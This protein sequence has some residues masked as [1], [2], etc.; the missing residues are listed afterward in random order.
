M[1][2][3]VRWVLA[4][5]L[6]VITVA[7]L[8]T[9]VLAMQA[10]DLKV[11]VD[12]NRALP[13]GHPYVATTRRIEAVFGKSNDVVVG[14]TAKNGDAFSPQVLSTVQRITTSLQSLPTVTSVLSLSAAR[15][16]GIAAHGD[17]VAV[18]P[19][20]PTVPM[21]P[22]EIDALRRAL[23]ANPVYR[24]AIISDD[25][26]TA[27]ILAEFKESAAGF[28]HMI[29]S[30][31]AIVQR[32]RDPSV[33]VAIGGQAVF[34]AKLEYYSE[35]VKFLFPIAVLVVGLIHY[36]AFRTLQG[37]ILPLV[38]AL[39][40]VVWGLGLMGLANV[41][42][43]AFNVTTPILI[44]AVA[45]G[46]AVQILKR[47]YEE[48]H[49]ITRTSDRTGRDANRGAVEASLLRVAP[50]MLAAGSV[51]ALGFLSLVV[52][53]ISTIRTFGIFTA[54]G[55]I[56]ALVLELSFIPA[57][58]SLLPAPGEVEHRR[59]RQRRVWDR[60]AEAIAAAVTGP[61][62]RFVYVVATIVLAI[63]I[64][65]VTRV[66]VD[67]PLRSYFFKNLPFQADD[68]LLN[69]RLGGTNT[70]YLLVEGRHDGAIK[71]ASVLR[72]MDATQR[73]LEAQPY[74]GKTISLVD[75]VKR[76]N[77]GMHNED[78]AYNEI[79]DSQDTIAQ[80]LLL[81][82]M[83]GEPADFDAYVD[84]HY[85]LADIRVFLKTDS[86]AYVQRLIAQ[87]EV[88]AREHFGDTAT[89]HFGGNLPQ[90]AALAERIVHEKLLNVV[91]IC[92][93]ILILA[94][95]M[96]RSVTAGFL[97]LVPLVFAVI[98]N[99]GLMGLTGIRLN[100]AT[101]VISAMAVG[102]GADYAIYLIFRLR[103]ELQGG[104]DEI[105]AFRTAIATAGKAILFVASAV[106]GGYGMLVFSWGFSIHIWF[107]LLIASAMVVSALAALTILPSLLLS[108]RPRFIFGS[109]GGTQRLAYRRTEID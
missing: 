6:T 97:I 70:L 72:A 74:V 54:L 30:V 44:F 64:W 69:D 78:P 90:T 81:Y 51:A 104:T 38:T 102:L 92:A 19:L 86:T 94:S 37:L 83:A 42:M 84:P 17:E 22:A 80:Y 108:L 34:L 16:K 52:F 75:F 95:V 35:R 20:M 76:L 67:T 53:D 62:R 73:F 93:V 109:A 1:R 58:R 88:F 56:S 29:N 48:Y 98:S 41:T 45:A 3:Y 25:G 101:S 47:Y 87:L 15:A 39:L 77:R 2:R 27:A 9:I 50:A 7:A 5:R 57:V 96:F 65:G 59:E 49:R 12:P 33:E 66:T 89:V 91:Q 23:E 31:Q 4:W 21:T 106:A 107:A 60:L 99:L 71:T 61:H 11:V 105:T 24:N 13:Q 28:Q 8:I 46:H 26:R 14:V 79:P 43:D 68:R 32:D 82:S 55:I 36:E 10:K 103:E 40:A 100:I 63:C 85:R 18:Q